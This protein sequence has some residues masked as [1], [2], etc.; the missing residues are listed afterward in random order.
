M[1]QN[2]AIAT[3][4]CRNYRAQARVLTA[5]FAESGNCGERVV[6]VLDDDEDS[7][8]LDEHL[9]RT[10]RPRDLRIPRFDAMAGYY[11]ALELS[12]AVKPWLLD[13]MIREYGGYGP[14]AYFDP[15]IE[16]V[17]PMQELL[18]LL[19]ET[20]IVVTPHMTAPARLDR[21]V[22]TEQALLLAGT[23]NLGFIALNGGR[24]GIGPFL[25]W[26][27][28]RLERGCLVDPP[29]GYFV[30]QRYIDFVPG[31]FDDV[32][33]LRHAGYNVAYWNLQSRPLTRST[34]GELL[35]AEE[36]VR[37]M[38]FSGFDPR[39]P[40]HVSKHQDR[41][42]LVEGTVLASVFASYGERLL[43]AGFCDFAGIP[44]AFDQS[45]S[46]RRVTKAVRAMVAHQ[47]AEHPEVS[48]LTPNGEQQFMAYLA[49]PDPSR[50][51]L[52]RAEMA[53]LRERPELDSPS[54]EVVRERVWLDGAVTCRFGEFV[55]AERAD[56][57]RSSRL[58]GIGDPSRF[59]TG[60]NV[61][62]YLQSSTGVGEVG[63]RMIRA[64]DH[65]AVPVWPVNLESK[66][67][68]G[69]VP[70]VAPTAAGGLPFGH[71]LVLA[72]ADVLPTVASAFDGAGFGDRFVT[73]MWWWELDRFPTAFV[74][75]FAHLDQLLAGSTFIVEALRRIAPIPVHRVPVPIYL[76][77]SGEAD[78]SVFG[79]AAAAS[80]FIFYFSFDYFSVFERKNPLGLVSAYTTAFAETDGAHLVIKA[81]N[82]DSHPDQQEILECATS[83]RSDITIINGF[84]EPRVRDLMMTSCDCYVSLHRSEG[85]G[86]TMGEA[87]YAGKPVIATAYSGNMDFMSDD[88]GMLIPYRMIP[89]G[90]GCGPYDAS[91]EWADPDLDEA[92]KAMRRLFFE[93]E[94]TSNVAERGWRS[95]RETNSVVAAAHA[96]REVFA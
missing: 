65:L 24:G 71:S 87:M 40:G 80:S 61:L 8:V 3:I 94:L 56:R 50:P 15:D 67:H 1:T 96:L 53:T 91:A 45:V 58:R 36:P 63:R 60:V 29:H 27:K 33:I 9:Y 31:M 23:Y 10:V 49:S 17:T 92:A 52:T 13:W 84:A 77:H 43:N 51:G 57:D 5:S 90:S 83:R 25:D 70:F 34:G 72:N 74:D 59:E 93:P 20:S 38:H 16:F 79:H 11:D 18:G 19:R 86:M 42:S 44:Y 39:K 55:S 4:I 2:L 62:G 68:E 82:A 22:P 66:L 76:S 14:V 30:D 32:G 85:L 12:T 88:N 47:S 48:L 64:L 7:P 37:F 95:I 54:N 89:V 81:I 26:W 78:R 35:A 41:I 46:G 28:E 21:H 73:G 6:L 75:S 69:R